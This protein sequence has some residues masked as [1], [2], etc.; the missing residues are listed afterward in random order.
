M[1]KIIEFDKAKCEE[2]VSLRD[3]HGRKW[4]EIAEAV[5]IPQG[6]CI[7]MYEWY[8]VPA[9]A[10]VKNPTAKDIVKFRNEGES[11][12]SIS[13]MTSISESSLRRMYE[14][15][16][17]KS[18]VGNRIGKGGRYPSNS[19]KPV[20]K[21]APAKKAPAKKAP[22]KK[23]PAVNGILIDMPDEKIS[24]A[25]SGFAVKVAT[26][27]GGEEVIKVASVKRVTKNT[28]TVSIPDGSSRTLKRA[29]V[30]QI[31]KKKVA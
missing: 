25:L 11:W 8:K 17:G 18:A 21:K 20:A 22:A 13:A 1:S 23:A 26:D 14:Q 24:N 29:S 30:F 5:S 15:A 31:S 7:L 27:T 12:G 16:T 2:I 10:R 3:S 28:V 9:K 6:K 4:H 19:E